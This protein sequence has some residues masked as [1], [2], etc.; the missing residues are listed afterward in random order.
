VLDTAQARADPFAVRVWPERLTQ[1]ERWAE[2]RMIF[3]NSMSDLFHHDIPD[4][5]TRQ[6]FEVM[7]RAD[8]HIYQVLTKRP[9]DYDALF[10]IAIQYSQM[11]RDDETIDFGK[12]ALEVRP[13]SEQAIMMVAMSYVN[14]RDKESARK[15]LP[16]LK[17]LRGNLRERLRR[18][19][20]MD[21]AAY[22]IEV[23][24]AYRGMW[25]RFCGS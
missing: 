15:Y 4:G 3:V 24:A 1:P 2:P 14:K 19:R 16:R 22:A 10:G 6:I 7:L 21:G 25:R 17:E 20:L 18:S 9:K 23:E 5:F 12:Q 13:E 8:W 11:S